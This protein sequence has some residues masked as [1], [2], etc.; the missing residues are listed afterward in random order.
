MIEIE[1]SSGNVYADLGIPDANEMRVKSQLA[2]K[3]GEIIKARRLTQVQASEILGLSQPKLSEMLR[4]KFR[5]ISEAKMMECLLL[6][7]RDVQIVVKSA[8]RSRKE[9]RIEVVFT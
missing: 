9:G 7:G 1:E 3:V 6:L 5:G 4:G 2:A 8:P